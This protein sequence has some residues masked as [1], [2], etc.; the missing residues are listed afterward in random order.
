MSQ[1]MPDAADDDVS[2]SSETDRSELSSNQHST[3][4]ML[5]FAIDQLSLEVFYDPGSICH[6][7][8]KNLLYDEIVRPLRWY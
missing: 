7:R 8:K 1:D 6:L 4:L 3:L 5:Q 2:C